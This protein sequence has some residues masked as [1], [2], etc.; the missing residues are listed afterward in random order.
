MV[1]EKEWNLKYGLDLLMNCGYDAS[2][3]MEIQSNLLRKDPPAGSLEPIFDAAQKYFDKHA[4]NKYEVVGG[5]SIFRAYDYDVLVSS[6]LNLV[7]G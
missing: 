2:K 1:P 3:A 6:I 5:G 7:K 4:E